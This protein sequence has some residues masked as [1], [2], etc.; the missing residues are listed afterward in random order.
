MQVPQLLAGA[1][2]DIGVNRL[3]FLFLASIALIIVG[4]FL[5]P[6]AAILV[7]VPL[8]LP[9]LAALQIDPIWFGVIL[10]INMELANITPPVGL[11]LFIIQAIEPNITYAEVFRGT[12]PF[13]IVIL[14]LLAIV[15]A[16]PQVAIWL[17]AR[18]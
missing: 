14:I 1:L 8:L 10:V 18:H 15:L 16:F 11:N 4:D 13:M 6:L 7:F 3:V 2:V 12:V 9:T 5:D 17:P